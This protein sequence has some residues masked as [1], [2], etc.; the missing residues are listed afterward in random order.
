MFSFPSHEHGN[1][2]TYGHALFSIYLEFRTT[3]KVHTP[4][5]PMQ[6]NAKVLLSAVRM[7]YLED[8]SNTV[9]RNGG[10]S[11]RTA[12]NQ[13][14]SDS[15]IQAKHL[16]LEVALGECNQEILVKV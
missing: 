8:G 7:K 10:D 9:Y 5:D 15:D 11:Y 3:D 1:R 12:R 16:A 14:T 4:S 6:S 13:I 2:S